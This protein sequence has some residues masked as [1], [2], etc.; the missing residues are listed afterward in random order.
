MPLHSSLGNRVRLHL[1]K[2]QKKEINIKR[3]ITTDTADVKRTVCIYIYEQLENN[4][5]K[6]THI[7]LT[8]Y[9]KLPNFM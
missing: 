5:N 1:K 3:D 4:I 6:S 9:M 2:K 7:N 8:A